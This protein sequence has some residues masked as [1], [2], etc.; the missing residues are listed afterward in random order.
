[1][2][3]TRI[4]T[5]ALAEMEDSPVASRAAD[6]PRRALRRRR[7]AAA[8]RRRVAVAVPDRLPD[9]RHAERRQVERR[10]DLPRAV[11]RPACGERQS[12]HRQA[13]L[14][15]RSWSA[16]ACRSTP[17]ATSSSAR[18]CSAAAWARPAPPRSIRRPA[19]PTG[20]IFPSSPSATWCARRRCWSTGS[21][22]T[23]CS[24]VLGGSMGGMQ[25]LQWAASFPER[26]FAA[27]PIACAARH[28]SQNIAFHEVGR[29]AVMADPDWCGGKYA[30]LGTQPA[31]G[32]R[33]RAHGRAHHLSVR[34]GAA[35]EIRARS[36]RTA[37]SSPSASTPISRSSPTSAT[38]ARPSSTAS[39]RTPIS[40]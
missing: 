37:P 30:E 13:G 31:Q 18:T 6:E 19:S 23:R 3:M 15:G 16:P 32:P 8:R 20:S 22:S 21:A 33:G 5:D 38:R 36:C 34:R 11:R 7:A 24:A 12:G 1:M 35:P 28:S 26:V 29:Q 40:T 39:T 14:V 10:A 25:V 2:A 9:L 17:T 4:E 27:V